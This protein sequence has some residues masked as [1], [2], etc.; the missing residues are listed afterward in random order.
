[1]G[2]RQQDFW[3]QSIGEWTARCAGFIEMHGG[4][5]SVEALTLAELDELME[6]H[7][8]TIAV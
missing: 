2:M 8:D 7:P 6:A 3:A 1:M 4:E 5:A